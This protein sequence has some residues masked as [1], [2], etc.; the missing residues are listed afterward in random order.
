MAFRAA[1]TGHQVFTTLHT[2]SAMGAI[3]RLGDIGVKPDIMSGNIIGVIGQRLVRSLCSHCK[4]PR[5]AEDYEQV[6]LGV[7]E[8]V[9]LYDAVGCKRC[10]G[11][12]YRGRRL[13]IE[14]LTMDEE[15]NELIAAGATLGQFE[16]H[17]R[18]QG[19]RTM[20]DDGVRLILQGVTT[21]EELSRV[22]DLTK[23]L[24]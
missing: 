15:L 8:P 1:M 23:R 3:P 22:V 2:N 21:V 11:I 24:R 6:I 5:P 10:N 19:F 7:E 4:T 12:G 17:A 20:A 13:V 9:T 18:S 16:Q 14:V